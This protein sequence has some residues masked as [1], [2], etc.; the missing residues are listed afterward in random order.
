MNLS[1]DAELRSKMFKFGLLPKLVGLLR[2]SST[3]SYM[4]MIEIIMFHIEI[5][6]YLNT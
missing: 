5:P 3:F 6:I 1:F 2:E 4:F